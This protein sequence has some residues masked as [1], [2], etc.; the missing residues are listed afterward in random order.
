MSKKIKENEKNNADRSLEKKGGERKED[1]NLTKLPKNVVKEISRTAAEHAIKAYQ[2]EKE[3]GR[4]KIKDKRFH[5]TKLLVQKYR[6][7]SE[8]GEKAIDEMG[9]FCSE[10]ELVTLDSMGIDVSATRKLESISNSI[11]T[12]Q[13]IMK[14]VDTMLDVYRAR[15]M[16]SPKPEV[17]RK[18][19]V[20]SEMYLGRDSL[21]VQEVAEIEKIHERTVYKDIDDACEELS[22]LF[23]GLDFSDLK[24][25]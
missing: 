23:F 11:V 21:S 24:L 22:S 4:A 25:E 17:K 6:W 7:L 16:A 10:E 1:V 14:H 12:T 15:C 13:I 20:L 8:F 19:R 5:N 2:D 9:Q 3:R 18:W